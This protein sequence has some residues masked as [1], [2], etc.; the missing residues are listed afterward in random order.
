MNET[1]ADIMSTELKTV[2]PADSLQRVKE[3]LMAHRIHHV[4]VVDGKKLV[5]LVT[6]YDLFKLNIDHKDYDAT[7]VSD[8]MTTKLAVIEPSDKIGT[9]AE[10]FM[11][12][13]FHAVPV[14]SEGNLVGIVTSFD[15]LKY[16]YTKEYPPRA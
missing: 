9:A 7:K 3:I 12:H 16:E 6:T 5:G 4:P 13:L 11:E 8:V 10:I 14:V 15:I 1:V 2:A